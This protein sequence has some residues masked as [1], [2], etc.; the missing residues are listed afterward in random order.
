MLINLETKA[1]CV[2][3]SASIDSIPWQVPNLQN[4]MSSHRAS[5]V[6]TSRQRP[7]R[8]ICY[9]DEI[10]GSVQRQNDM[11][12]RKC[13]L[14]LLNIRCFLVAE[15]FTDSTWCSR[16]H[17]RSHSYKYTDINLYICKNVSDCGLVHQV[18]SVKSSA[19]KKHLMLRR[20]R[21]H[22]LHDISLWRWTLP[23]LIW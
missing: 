2:R 6:M 14:V 17:S 15:D 18:E 4:V 11:S 13:D 20:T 19:T 16:P 10:K 3:D 1:M 22:F 21:S 12:C 5:L 23:N 8:E 9:Y 7:W